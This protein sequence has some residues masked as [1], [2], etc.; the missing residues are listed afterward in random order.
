MCVSKKRV[1]RLP[2]RRAGFTLIEVMVAMAILVVGMTTILGLLSFGLALHRTSSERADASRAAEAVVAQLRRELFTPKSLKDG[3]A[4]ANPPEIVA[5]RPVPGDEGL[6]Y[7]AKLHENPK[8]AGEYFA[9][10]EISWKEKGR[11]RFQSFR[12]ILL[13]E[14]PFAERLKRLPGKGAP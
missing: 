6:F 9:E 12:T 3:L 7:T 10:I 2:A 4:P 5:E 11:R 8:L 1:L 14:I 13:Q